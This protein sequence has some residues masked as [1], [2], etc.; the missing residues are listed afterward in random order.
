M[1]ALVCVC[2]LLGVSYLLTLM[3]PS[4]PRYQH[5]LPYV[6]DFIL[7]FQVNNH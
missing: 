3:V 1:Q 4:S 2:P 6:R 7:S 5:I